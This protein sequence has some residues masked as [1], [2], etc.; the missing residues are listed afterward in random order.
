MARVLRRIFNVPKQRPVLEFEADWSAIS[1]AGLGLV[2][3]E[4]LSD[5]MG[6]PPPPEVLEA[7]ELYK[8]AWKTANV[9]DIYFKRQMVGSTKPGFLVRAVIYDMPSLIQKTVSWVI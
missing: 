5:F 1:P 3:K 9:A 2:F 6:A 4:L 7:R 8:R